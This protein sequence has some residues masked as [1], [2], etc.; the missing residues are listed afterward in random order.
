MSGAHFSLKFFSI[1]RLAFTPGSTTR[2]WWNFW[3]HFNLFF[4]FL[5]FILFFL[6]FFNFK[7]CIYM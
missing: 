4:Y 7:I 5:F 6:Y 2:T 1:S 3:P